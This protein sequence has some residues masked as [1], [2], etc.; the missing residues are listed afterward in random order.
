MTKVKLTMGATLPTRIQY[1]NVEPLVEV[2]ADTF[3]EAR[4]IALSQIKSIADI[5]R[6]NKPMILNEPSTSGSTIVL[7]TLTDMFGNT[8][9]MDRINH[10]YQ[11]KEGK[12]YLSGSTFSHK[13][14]APFPQDQIANATATKYGV[15]AKDVIGMWDTN[16]E[17]S[18]SLG[19]AI[20]AALE[21]FGKYKDTSMATKDGST[22][23]VVHK[24]PFLKQVQKI[25]FADRKDE[26]AMYEAFVSNKDEMLCGFID[27]LKIIDLDK[28]IARIQDYKTNPDLNK[29]TGILDPFKE[30]IEPTTL[31]SYWLQLSFY[32]YLLFKEGW[33]IEGLD[34]FNIVARETEDGLLRL[35]LQE[36]SHEVIDISE[37]LQRLKG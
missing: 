28:K 15:D 21:L 36:F 26:V 34:I 30:L 3:E 29:K 37:G 12:P 6:D 1:E 10:T 23:A 22:V 31:G 27:R 9:Y 32:A 35:E 18:T 19:T 2:E 8:V 11:D 20:H 24:N 7:E 5:V 14:V 17:A 16:A 13:F 4:D 33:I 25:F